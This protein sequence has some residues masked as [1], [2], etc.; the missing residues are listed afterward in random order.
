[1][2]A[3]II[4]ASGITRD[5]G[6][7]FFPEHN[8]EKYPWLMPKAPASA[9]CDCPLKCRNCWT[10]MGPDIWRKLAIGNRRVLIGE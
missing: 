9:D 1:M 7:D 10:F 2:E 3:P 6:I 5:D 8:S 4:S